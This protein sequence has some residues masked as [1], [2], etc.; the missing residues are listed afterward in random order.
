MTT[1]L[2]KN[3]WTLLRRQTFFFLR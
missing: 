3:C 2:I 1:Q